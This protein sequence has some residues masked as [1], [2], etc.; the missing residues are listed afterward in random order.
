MILPLLNSTKFG[1]EVL[2]WHL[3]GS[4]RPSE[5][6]KESDLIP[7]ICQQ[8][9]GPTYRERRATGFA[10]A[11]ENQGNGL[12]N[13]GTHRQKGSDRVDG[14]PWRPQL[15]EIRRRICNAPSHELIIKW[16]IDRAS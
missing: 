2:R 5:T 4:R 12:K 9:N 14:F 10:D 11:L 7:A 8:E 6:Y 3:S 15:S 13:K 16:H 1:P